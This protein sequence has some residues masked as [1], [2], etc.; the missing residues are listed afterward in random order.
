[1]QRD[2]ACISSHDFQNHYAVVRFCG[3]VQSIERFGCDVKRSYKP[4]GEFRTCEI[5]V[6]GLGNTDNR[7]PQPIELVSNREGTFTA[8]YDQPFNAKTIEI[9]DCLAIDVLGL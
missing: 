2:P 9:L 8:E 7:N 6:D 3:R 5:V 1:M 4:E